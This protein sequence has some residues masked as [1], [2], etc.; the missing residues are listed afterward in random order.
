MGGF[1]PPAEPKSNPLLAIYAALSLLMLL[2]GDR[3]PLGAVRGVGATLFAPL[4]RMVLVGDR[5]SAAWSEN[6][7]LHRRIADLELENVR[8]RDS[9]VEN[10]R[11]REQLDLAARQPHVL[12]PVEVLA[13]SGEPVPSAATLSAGR[14]QGVHEGD[15][16]IARDGLVGRV[17]EVHTSLSRA[18]LLTDANQAV[19][20][21]VEST[22]VMGVLH[23]VTTP[24]PRLV[25]T[26]VAF[27]DTVGVGQRVVT[28]GMS[29]HYPRGIPVGAVE[30][31]DREAGGLMQDI[32]V[33]PAVRLSRL[34]HAFVI[35]RPESLAGRP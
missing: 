13:L 33:A 15:V 29:R 34:R 20:C 4:D 8:L 16:V 3:L 27:A 22:G 17:S 2:A 7:R 1:L 25:L 10:A 14:R 12:K 18:T 21:E 28:S 5:L 23:Y 26:G 11:L 24:H 35:A 31:V 32:E 30:H 19:A 6:A 9:G